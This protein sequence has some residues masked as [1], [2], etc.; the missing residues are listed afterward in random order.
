MKI[1]NIYSGFITG[2]LLILFSACSQAPAIATLSE[3]PRSTI[4]VDNN[5]IVR[6]ELVPKDIAVLSFMISGKIVSTYVEVG[7]EVHSGD[8]LVQLDTTALDAEVIRAENLLKIAQTQYDLSIEKKSD[9]DA[10]TIASANV[11]IADAE[12][13]RARYTLTQSVLVAPFDGIIVNMLVEPGE[14]ATPGKEIITLANLRSM[15]VET[16]DLDEMYVSNVFVGQA[17]EVY[18]NALDITINGH[19]NFISPRTEQV[20]QSKTCKVIIDLD[21]QPQGLLWGMSADTKFIID[22]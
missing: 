15:Q 12:L 14:I 1:R 5:P 10:Q 20:G 11:A 7:D 17:V 2:I 16:I 18:V 3:T 8:N 6:S 21:T 4:N 9:I 19:V 13:R 22:N